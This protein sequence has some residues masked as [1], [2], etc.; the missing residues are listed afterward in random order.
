M[1]SN[2]AHYYMLRWPQW[3][4]DEKLCAR[5]ANQEVHIYEDGN[6][7]LLK[8]SFMMIFLSRPCKNILFY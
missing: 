7:G 3:T 5:M 2:E 4:A 1:I 6:F 8:N